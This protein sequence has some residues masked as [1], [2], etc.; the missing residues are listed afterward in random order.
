MLLTVAIAALALHAPA[1]VLRSHA[2]LVSASARGRCATPAMAF[3]VEAPIEVGA[4]LP[5]VEVEVMNNFD[6]AGAVSGGARR[7]RRPCTWVLTGR[8]F[9]SRS[10]RA[11]WA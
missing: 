10:D 8:A 9:D 11:H 2:P 3:S 6:G 4:M 7:T 1:P 5:N